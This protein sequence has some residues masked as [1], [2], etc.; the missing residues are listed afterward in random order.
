MAETPPRSGIIDL[1]AARDQAAEE[2]GRSD[3]SNKTGDEGPF[4][5]FSWMLGHGQNKLT[6]QVIPVPFANACLQERCAIW[7]AERQQCSVLTIAQAH[8]PVPEPAEAP[9]A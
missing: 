3:S 4:C 1:S 2:R 7:N 6:N 5:P 8:A 9:S